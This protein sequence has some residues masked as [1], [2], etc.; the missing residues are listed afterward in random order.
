MWNVWVDN[1]VEKIMEMAQ[2]SRC[3]FMLTVLNPADVGTRTVS[4]ENID[5]NF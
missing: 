5:L 1:R 4:L 3:F 2:T